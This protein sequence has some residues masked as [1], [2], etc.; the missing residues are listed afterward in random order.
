MDNRF[1]HCSIRSWRTEAWYLEFIHNAE[2]LITSLAFAT[3]SA[4]SYIVNLLSCHYKVLLFIWGKATHAS[5]RTIQLS[6][7]RLCNEGVSLLSQHRWIR[8]STHSIPYDDSGPFV[9]VN[10]RFVFFQSPF[11]SPRS[12]YNPHEGLANLEE[13]AKKFLLTPVSYTHLDVY[14]RQI[15]YTYNI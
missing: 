9:T 5:A 3:H 2:K 6:R 12:S 4:S 15:L 11:T 7:R 8:A 10:P 13:V 1:V 14:K